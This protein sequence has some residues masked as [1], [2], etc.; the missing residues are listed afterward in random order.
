M[1]PASVIK[2]VLPAYT[3]NLSM[4]ISDYILE[5]DEES[6][7]AIFG[8]LEFEITEICYEI[9][10]SSQCFNCLFLCEIAKVSII[11]RSNCL[12]NLS[13]VNASPAVKLTTTSMKLLNDFVYLS[14]W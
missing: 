8:L 12:E 7:I 10:N 5:V 13:G 14:Y 1:V 4:F 2:T 3:D 6:N 9:D 11:R